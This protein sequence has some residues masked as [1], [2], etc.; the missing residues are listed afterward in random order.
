MMRPRALY[1]VALLHVQIDFVY[2]IADEM[3]AVCFKYSQVSAVILL[4]EKSLGSTVSRRLV[5]R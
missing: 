2:W 1:S 3:A 4:F 5:A